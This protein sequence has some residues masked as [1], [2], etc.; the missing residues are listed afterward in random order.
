[1]DKAFNVF[2][3]LT[4]NDENE[5]K[6]IESGIIQTLFNL[7]N[8]TNANN[9]NTEI[10]YEILDHLYNIYLRKTENALIKNGIFKIIKCFI[11]NV[12]NDQ[13]LIDI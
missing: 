11:T 1:M 3:T 12:K 10:C 5:I 2:T 9:K 4:W 13:Y 7:C 6:L 8:I